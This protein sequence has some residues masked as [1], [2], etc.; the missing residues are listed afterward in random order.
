MTWANSIPIRNVYYML[1]Y[2]FTGLRQGEFQF[3]A[4]EPF[5]NIQDLFAAILSAG[6]G[7]Q[8]KL[9]L[10]RTYRTHTQPLK[11][12]RGHIQMSGTIRSRVA[13]QNAITCTYEALTENNIFNQILKTALRLLITHQ[14]VEEKYR[15]ILKQ[16]YLL[17]SRVDL[18]DPR[19]IPWHTLSYNRGN[20]SYQLLVELCR[21]LLEGMLLTTEDG[22]YRLA[23]FLDDAHM[24]QIY[25][26]FLLGYYRREWPS[27]RAAPEQ[28]H[29]ALD[30]GV[31]VLLP[32]MQT[33][34][35]LRSGNTV[36]ILDAKFYAQIAQE[37]Y[38]RE[39]IRS[40]HL[41]Q[42][43]SYVKNRDAAFGD[44]PHAV[45]GMLLYAAT[46]EAMRISHTY[47]MD[48]NSIAVQTLDLSRPFSEIA[49]ELD[50]IA[51]RF[52]PDA[53][54]NLKSER[55]DLSQR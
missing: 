5:E 12:V 22:S 32:T 27:L 30:D 23:A 42:I 9:G 34:I 54:R 20:Q 8:L 6:V 44:R 18:L 1:A 55:L 10:Y 15:S 35:T 26:K 25:E 4:G 43:Y 28:V 17:F 29:W 11:T 39:T 38:G 21:L 51:N 47:S 48:G 24:Y 7:R 36:L 3:L 41:Y 46:K 19:R 16:E 33:D 31:D 13:R 40:A 49:A 53:Q 14:D 37:R 2:A 45:S 50:G 52:F